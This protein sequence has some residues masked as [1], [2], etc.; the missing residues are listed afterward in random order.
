[1]EKD[2]WSLP[3][4]FERIESM[5]EEVF[6]GVEEIEHSAW[7]LHDSVRALRV[8]VGRLFATQSDY[9]DTPR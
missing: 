7:E 8:A 6:E 1:M 4:A 2:R 5:K 3:P 9:G